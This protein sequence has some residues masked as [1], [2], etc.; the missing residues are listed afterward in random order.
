MPD[1]VFVSLP[2]CY[3]VTFT[4]CQDNYFR[5]PVI[6]S[7]VLLTGTSYPSPYFKK[8]VMKNLNFKPLI[9]MATLFSYFMVHS[10][11]TSLP[12]GEGYEV[13]LNNKLLV[14]QFGT[15]SDVKNISLSQVA[16]GDQ[17]S[18]KY[19]HC[20]RVGKNRSVYIK[21]KAN[22]KLIEWKYA[23]VSQPVAAMKFKISDVLQLKKNNGEMFGVYYTSSELPKGR[24]LIKLDPNLEEISKK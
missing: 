22:A 11:F 17:I 23:D 7:F 5:G 6:I 4:V 21:N 18:I 13:Y 1:P 8:Y 3:Q 12:G 16:A 9:V 14:Q 10:S 2:V 15:K 24:L 20:G 19:F